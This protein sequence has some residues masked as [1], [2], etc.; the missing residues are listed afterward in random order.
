M[1]RELT[2][3]KEK[4]HQQLM[5]MRMRK[6]NPNPIDVNISEE[7]ETYSEYNR[8]DSAAAKVSFI[9]DYIGQLNFEG[10]IMEPGTYYQNSYKS[11]EITKYLL[12]EFK[13]FT[14]E[15]EVE[16]KES[17]LKIQIPE[18]VLK[19]LMLEMY[20]TDDVQ[21]KMVIS[22]ILCD[23]TANTEL[24]SNFYVD[25]EYYTNIIFKM[26]Y[27]DNTPLIQ[28]LLTI[29]NNVFL[30]YPGKVFDVLQRFPFHVRIFE[31]LKTYGGRNEETKNFQIELFN[32][33][34]SFCLM[35]NKLKRENFFEV[36][37][38]F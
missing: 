25:N 1:K 26:T 16:D 19:N 38:K 34:C 24:V 3:R 22:S 4:I 29:M 14:S 36:Y 23:L 5:E 33:L 28:N 15:L 2:L 17:E 35:I 12:N 32:I 7:N 37:F 27:L 6:I 13:T 30:D 31:L 9:A 21:V 20:F 10:F 11:Q 8:I 18:E